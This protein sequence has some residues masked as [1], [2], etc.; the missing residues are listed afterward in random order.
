MAPTKIPLIFVR[1]RSRIVK[2]NLNWPQGTMT[3]GEPGKNG[4]RTSDLKED[5]FDSPV[6]RLLDCGERARTRLSADEIIS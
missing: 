5:R 2:I 1:T 4:V 3:I 6:K